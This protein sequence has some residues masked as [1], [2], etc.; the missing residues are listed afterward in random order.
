MSH[1]SLRPEDITAI[2]DT[3]EKRPWTLAPLKTIERKLDTGDYSIQGLSD[4]GGVVVERK[5]LP[6]LLNCTG[7]DRERWERCLARMLAYPDRIVIVEAPFQELVMGTWLQAENRGIQSKMHPNA[8]VGSVLG[9]MAL[10]IPF[11]FCASPQEAS[12]MAARFL[13]IAARRRF[14]SLR[15]FHGSLRLS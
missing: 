6:D 4:P 9:W 5:S 7:G 1:A 13:F 10:G 2:I 12:T 14:A 11:L 8:V 3:Q 15:A